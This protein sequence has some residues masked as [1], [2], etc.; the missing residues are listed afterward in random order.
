MFNL[1]AFSI[2]YGAVLIIS[3]CVSHC[4]VSMMELKGVITT[5][6][7]II[8]SEQQHLKCQYHIM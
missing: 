3:V 6:I 2:V 8:E 1:L 4:V 7:I 5:T